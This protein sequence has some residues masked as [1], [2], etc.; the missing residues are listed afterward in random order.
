MNTCLCGD[1]IDDGSTLCPR[2]IALQALDLDM[3]ATEAEIRKAYRQLV[4]VWGP[5]SFEGDEKLKESAEAK[6]NGINS[7]FEFLTLTSTERGPWRPPLRS[8]EDTDSSQSQDPSAAAPTQS[9]NGGTKPL[10]T[11]APSSRLRLWTTTGFF[12][13]AALVLFALL[14]GRYVLIAFAGQ[15]TAG[16]EAPRVVGGKP[17]LMNA[18]VNAL[19]AP[20]RRFVEAVE[21][22]LR[23]LDPRN[24]APAPADNPLAARPANRQ[25]GESA[26]RKTR[27]QSPDGTPPA[28]RKLLPYITVGSTRDEVLAQQGTPTASSENKLVYGKSELYFKDGAVVGWRIDPAAS[29]LRVKLWPSSAVNPALAS[30]TVGSS[31]DEV[32]TVQGTPTAF[33]ED[34]FE[35]G[36]SIVNFRNNRV[37]SWKEDPDSVPLWAR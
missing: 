12:L 2:C 24:S 17:N 29:P 20:K 4:K 18:F 33:T 30:F 6:L 10:M 3:N 27:S 28:P 26:A 36:R 5:D 13:K 14:L 34:K 16:V 31:K 37:V 32:L 21:R 22:D 19:A 15:D 1:L 9:S 25:A 7:A 35:Y 8:P 11:P 23:R